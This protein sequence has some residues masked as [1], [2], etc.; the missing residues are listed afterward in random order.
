MADQQ[1]P[2]NKRPHSESPLSSSKVGTTTTLTA[3]TPPDGTKGFESDSSLA[4]PKHPESASNSETTTT[5]SKSA[6]AAA[7]AA[8]IPKLTLPVR[9]SDLIGMSLE[10]RLKLHDPPHDPERSTRMERESREVQD[11][12][13]DWFRKTSRAERDQWC[14]D[15]GVGHSKWTWHSITNANI[16]RSAG[17]INPIFGK[18]CRRF[19]R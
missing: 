12:V 9:P 1:L 15:H 2:P 14:I 10:E 11:R 8:H 16:P 19:T 5:P 13:D 18:C 4:S 7:A 17:Q 3:T 6:A